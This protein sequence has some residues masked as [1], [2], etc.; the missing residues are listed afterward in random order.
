MNCLGATGDLRT[1]LGLFAQGKLR[2]VLDTV[3]RSDSAGAA[4]EFLSRTFCDR[5]RLGKVVSRYG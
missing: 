3:I 5:G 2:V 4:G 1:S